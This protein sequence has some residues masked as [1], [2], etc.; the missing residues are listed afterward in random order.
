VGQTSVGSGDGRAALDRGRAAGERF[1]WAAAFEALSLADRSTPLGADDLGLLSTAAYLIGRVP[2]C[3]ATLRRSYEAHLA[4]GQ[5]RAAART[6]FW[7]V[8][9][10]GNQGDIAQAGGW[11]ARATQLLESQPPDCAERGLVLGAMAFGRNMAGEFT[12]A[13][14]LAR[15]AAEIGRCSGDPD[16]R[17]LALTQCAGALTRLGRPDEAIP[18]LDEAM[19]AVISAEI[20]PIAAGTIYC[21]V[22][23]VCQEAAEL[24]RAR[25]WTEALDAWCDRQPD[26]VAFTGQ[27][28]VHRAELLQLRGRLPEAVEEAERA[29]ARLAGSPDA[30][31]TGAARYRQAEILRVCGDLTSAER[32][33]QQASAWGHELCPG[34]ALLRL[35]QRDIEAAQALMRRALAETSDPLGRARLLPAQVEIALDAGD[36]PSARSAADELADTLPRYDTPAL[37]ATAGYAR[38]A[39]LL[40]EGDPAGGL[41]ALRT[42]GTL[43]RDLDVPYELACTRVLIGLACRD[44]GDQDTATIELDAA[45]QAFARLGAEPD[46][47]RVGA[48]LAARRRPPHGLTARELQVLRLIATGKTN[49]AIAAELAL[50]DKTVERHV[51]NL[52]GKLGVSS[53]A[54]ATAYAYQHRLL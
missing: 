12:Q 37:R 20:S 50:A 16:A 9:V 35:A 26:M 53:R 29:C 15:Q 49:R 4:A 2:D 13:L 23:S 31:V 21:T 19:V 5:P 36:L 1:A 43:W 17:G 34:L 51:S 8:Y 28:L 11:L 10:L 18:M 27:C 6:A 25:E 33:Y 52:F 54:A 45:V 32:A 39:V 42:A 14:D 41:T 44:L 40:A 38:G 30:V 48:M 3:V 47:V 24:R 7:I 46:R 22:I